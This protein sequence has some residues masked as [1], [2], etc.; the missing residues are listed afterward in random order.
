M[1]VQ[2]AGEQIRQVVAQ[3]NFRAHRLDVVLHEIQQAQLV[4][5]IVQKREE[6]FHRTVARAAAEA[7]DGGVEKI[8]ASMMLRWCWRTRAAC[9]CACARPLPCRTI[10]S[11]REFS[12]Q[13]VNAFAV[14]R[15]EA[16]HDVNGLGLGFSQ[17]FQA[18]VQF[19]VG[20]GRGGHEVDGGFV[21]FVVRV[22]DHFQRGWN[23]WM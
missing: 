13:L 2:H 3:S 21:A 7:G 19:T 18:F 14:K 22:L 9:C 8:R 17:H 1:L 5:R 15:A 6:Q 11:S 20:N 16:V 23:W 4:F 12:H 10:C